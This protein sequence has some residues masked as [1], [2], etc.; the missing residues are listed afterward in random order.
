MADGYAGIILAAGASHRMGQPKALLKWRGRTFIANLLACF[1]RCHPTM[2][3]TGTHDAEL[4]DALGTE[5]CSFVR[6]PD[7]D[8]GQFSSLQLGLAE[9]ASVD[10][11]LVTPC[12][13]PLR[14]ASVVASLIRAHSEHAEICGVAYPVAD[15]QRGH[16]VL[17]DQRLFSHLLSQAPT[18]RTD[19]ALETALSRAGLQALDIAVN[20]RSI[21]R[22]INTSADYQQLLRRAFDG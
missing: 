13:L 20:D 18:A 19:H 11:A 12:D 21:L 1:E 8:R 14:D 22:N 2:I 17:V 10:A 3:I 15:G 6:N 7:P 5:R 16:P 9:L 4:R